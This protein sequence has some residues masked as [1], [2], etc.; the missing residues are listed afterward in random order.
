[1]AYMMSDN[2]IPFRA[3]S[4]RNLE[5]ASGFT[6]AMTFQVILPHFFGRLQGHQNIFLC[7]K[8]R[9]SESYP[10]FKEG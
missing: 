5:I 1:M 4:A 8:I 2:V 3:V 10:L 7:D 6:T 9:M